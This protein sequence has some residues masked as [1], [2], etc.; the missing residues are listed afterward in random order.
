[1]QS[2]FIEMRGRIDLLEKS[3]AEMAEEFARISHPDFNAM[4]MPDVAG[5]SRTAGTP[6]QFFQI[7]Q[8][9]AP[10]AEAE[11]QLT[12]VGYCLRLMETATKLIELQ[13]RYIKEGPSEEWDD[14]NETLKQDSNKFLNLIENAGDLRQ[15]REQIYPVLRIDEESYYKQYHKLV[16]G[17]DEAQDGFVRWMFQYA[18]KSEDLVL[19][20]FD[21]RFSALSDSV[22]TV[23]LL[24]ERIQGD[25]AD[26]A[27]IRIAHDEGIIGE[28]PLL[29][30]IQQEKEDLCRQRL[31]RALAMVNMLN[32]FA[33]DLQEMGTDTLS[34][35]P[36]FTVERYKPVSIA[37]LPKITP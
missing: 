8:V 11:Y 19:M 25:M 26:Y 15:A 35:D 24:E 28:S 16:Q 20:I 5:F 4:E 1:M 33:T 37:I 14:I 23:E 3:L 9:D 10:E 34:H 36:H 30:K 6:K 7:L 31:P 21:E 13:N 32:K 22:S 18:T 12:A 29:L 2:P 27:M 17:F